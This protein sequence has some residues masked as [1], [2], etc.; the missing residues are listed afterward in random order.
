MHMSKILF[1]KTVS[2][3][4]L[5]QGRFFVLPQIHKETAIEV[6]KLVLNHIPPSPELINYYTNE[7]S[8]SLLLSVCICV[9]GG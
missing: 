9:C 7:S 3:I 4:F 1:M 8:D 2:Q 6:K 5:L